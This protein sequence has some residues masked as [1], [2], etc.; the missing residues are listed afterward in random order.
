[1]TCTEINPSRTRKTMP[2]AYQSTYLS[3]HITQST[4][5][6]NK[7]PYCYHPKSP[8]TTHKSHPRPPY[9]P[10]FTTVNVEI[11]TKHHIITGIALS[12]HTNSP[13]F[14]TVNVEMMWFV[15]L[16]V[17]VSRH[18]DK[19]KGS[20]PLKKETIHQTNIGLQIVFISVN[21]NHTSLL[22]YVYI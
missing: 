10:P 17:Y 1:M 15:L 13:P 12:E 18:L 6:I 8:F 4:H 9:S 20:L 19:L 16:S 11:L 3:S 2:Y 14:T 21:Y 7:T 5:A 22:V